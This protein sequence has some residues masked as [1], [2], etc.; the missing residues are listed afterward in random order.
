[1]RWKFVRL[2]S[3]AGLAVAILLAMIRVSLSAPDATWFDTLTLALWSSAFYLAVLQARE[4]VKI[5]A[6]A[7]A[8]AI[9][10]NPLVYGAVGWLVWRTL[11]TLK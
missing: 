1:M 2:F 4:Q 8:I 9:S 7:Y 5:V 10:L 11:R 3:L 6:A